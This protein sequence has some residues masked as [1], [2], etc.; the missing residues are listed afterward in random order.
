MIKPTITKS[1]RLLAPSLLALAMTSA[2]A[3]CV[4]CP[5]AKTD[6][7]DGV[8]Q[9]Q[10]HASA[11]INDPRT[12]LPLRT[13]SL[14]Y[15]IVSGKGSGSVVSQTLQRTQ[16]GQWVRHTIDRRIEHI[17]TNEAGEVVMTAVEDLKQNVITRYDPP[18]LLLPAKMP[19]SKVWQTNSA[20]RVLARNN[21]SKLVDQGTCTQTIT[22]DGDGTT[23]TPAGKFKSYRLR[24]NYKAKLGM[25]S[26]STVESN[27]YAPA[28]GLVASEYTETVKA[29]I[30]SWTVHR[31][32]LL[33][34][35]PG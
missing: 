28:V 15:R 16:S 9:A 35:P 10:P 33:A 7:F 13:G 18:L 5:T 2:M 34:Q 30:L 31:K 3:G 29:L 24:V 19:P 20:M 17:A 26:V 14:Q 27:Y 23:I 12:L 21:P 6:A 4:K 25:A 32:F 11:P 22:Y 8:F 1:I